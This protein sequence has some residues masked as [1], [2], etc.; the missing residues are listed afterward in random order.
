MVAKFDF[1]IRRMEVFDLPAVLSIDRM[2]FTDPWPES[3]YRHELYANP[4]ARYFV[5]ELLDPAL[6]HEWSDVRT[7]RTLRLLGYT[8]MRVEGTR[9]H[10]STLAL[11]PDWHGQRLGELLFLTGLVQALHDG[12]DSMALEVRIHND[13]AQGLYRK[14]GFEITSHL[15]RYYTNGGDAYLM[16]VSFSDEAY[17]QSV[18]LRLSALTESLKVDF[19]A[20]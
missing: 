13:A 12:A 16:K 14:Y 18:Y 3:V 15:H 6:T 9:G 17:C 8:G 7:M 1:R 20:W 4:V 11:R 5:L 2:V 10:I 19:K